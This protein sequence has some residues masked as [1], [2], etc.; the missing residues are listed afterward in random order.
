MLVPA[1]TGLNY[2]Y[3]YEPSTKEYYLYENGHTEHTFL[4][5][6]YAD[7]F[8]KQIEYYGSL[9]P[10]ACNSGLLVENLIKFFLK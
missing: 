7:L 2:S 8:A 6:K 10:P 9:P 3:S 5:G 1:F 4:K